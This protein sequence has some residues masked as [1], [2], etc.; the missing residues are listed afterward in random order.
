MTYVTETEYG[1]R[2]ARSSSWRVVRPSFSMD[3]R[4]RVYIYAPR[5]NRP[6][7]CWV[8]NPLA[9]TVASWIVARLNEEREEVQ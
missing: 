6:C 7:A 9:W 3:G 5:Q 2:L 8:D 1:Q 4:Q